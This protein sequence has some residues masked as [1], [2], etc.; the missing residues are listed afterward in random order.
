[1]L[2]CGCHVYLRI[3][4]TCPSM[5]ERG[6]AAT[7][8]PC[9]YIYIYTYAM[10]IY[11]VRIYIGKLSRNLARIYS[12]LNRGSMFFTIYLS[13]LVYWVGFVTGATFTTHL[14]I[15]DFIDFL[16]CWWK[17]AFKPG[18][19]LLQERCLFMNINIFWLRYVMSIYIYG[20]FLLV[21]PS[22]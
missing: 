1:M 5:P 2:I 6:S 4:S 11:H 13:D 21:I 12:G 14:W 18:L 17:S 8:G 7:E 22:C 15:V 10:H 3:Y 20:F 9:I 16:T 19:L